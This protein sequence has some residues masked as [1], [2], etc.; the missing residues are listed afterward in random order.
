L[1]KELQCTAWLTVQSLRLCCKHQSVNVAGSYG[2]K[3]R[4]L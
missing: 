3:R 2:E 1:F 4:Q